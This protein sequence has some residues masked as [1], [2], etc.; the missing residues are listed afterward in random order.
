M[1]ISPNVFQRIE[2]LEN[3][4]ALNFFGHVY[5]IGTSTVDKQIPKIITTQRGILYDGKIN[6]FTHNRTTR[7][8]PPDT[9][10]LFT[11][12]YQ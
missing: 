1:D 3:L 8:I 5:G 7:T 6:I 9:N 4:V 12:G 10:R 11:F 2:F